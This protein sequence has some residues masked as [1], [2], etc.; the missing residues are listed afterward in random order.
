MKRALLGIVVV[1][2]LPLGGVTQTP[3]PLV[4]A[5]ERMKVTVQSLDVPLG[6]PF[7]AKIEL[8]PGKLKVE[9]HIVQKGRSGYGYEQGSGPAKVVRDEGTTKVIEITPLDLG[10]IDVN[11]GGMYE[12]GAVIDQTLHLNVVPSAKKLKSFMFRDGSPIPM[13]LVLKSREDYGRAWLMPM[14]VF[15]GVKYPVYGFDASYVPI[16]VE[17]PADNPVIRV[18]KNGLVQGLRP[19]KAV[20]VADI[21]G[22]KARASV[23]VYNVEDAPWEWTSNHIVK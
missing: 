18:D 12:D 19:G 5:S 17:Q 21:D 14:Y 20:I 13:M 3:S 16:T 4:L 15:D 9:L 10:P 2:A 22:F 6:V 8:A 23:T 7:Q 1:S 11:L